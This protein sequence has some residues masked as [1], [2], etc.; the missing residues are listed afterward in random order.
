[1]AEIKFDILE[2]IGVV[3]T[4]NKNWNKELNIISWNE[5]PG[6]YDLRDWDENH[7]KMGKGITLTKEELKS[8]KEL[9]N[10]MDL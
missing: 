10:Q 3:S 7:Q 2:K 9:L 1:M 8:L 4:S 5:R 6:K